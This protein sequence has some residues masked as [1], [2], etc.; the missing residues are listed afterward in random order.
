MLNKLFTSESEQEP[1]IV[2][3]S[4]PFPTVTVAIPTFNEEQN[5]ERI[6]RGFLQTS[7]RNLIEIYI[8]DGGSTDSTCA[9]IQ[10]ISSEDSRV[11]LIDNP[12]RLQ[13]AGLNRILHHCQG[14][15]LLRADAHSDYA[16]DYIEQCISALVDSQ[17]LN[18]GGAQRFVAKTPF[19]AGI[20]LATKSILGSGGARYR[21]PGYDG[22]A[23]TVY[24]GCFW[25]EALMHVAGYDEKATPNEDTEL[26]VRLQVAF[27]QTQVTNQDAE[28]NQRLLSRNQA[29]IYISSKIKAWY[30][31]R[32]SWL[33]LWTQYFKYGRGRC[34]TAIKH[35]KR[36]Q[37]RGKLPFIAIATVTVL[38]LISLFLPSL[39]P[40][41]FA[42]VCTGGLAVVLESLR[43]TLKYD[44]TFSDEIWRGTPNKVPSLFKRTMLCSVTLF[45][46]PIAHFSGYS[47]QLLRR[48]LFRISTW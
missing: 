38:S 28:L 2:R 34:L 45:T 26:N 32:K 24:L 15:V 29:A 13:S 46:M 11:K 44:R 27:D 17:A 6:I 25:R 42:L 7:Y 40:I 5:I 37:I 10:R 22:Y 19:Q 35:A 18:A 23:D 9:I 48:N 20:A 33:A 12:L 1:Y 8:A 43:V 16:P 4:S 3:G 31:P 41:V 21:D 30:Y 14:E 39:Q 47:Y 36:S